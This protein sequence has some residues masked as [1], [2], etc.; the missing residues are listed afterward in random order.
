MYKHTL[1]VNGEY[2]AKA[3][4]LPS[5]AN[6]V[7]NGGSIKAGS[8]MGAVEVVMA[9]VDEVSIPASTLLTVQ[10]EGSDDN[11]NFALMPVNYALTTS[12]GVTTYKKGEEFARLPVPSNAP[13]HVRCRIATDKAGVTG[14]VDVFCDFLP[15]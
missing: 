6:A 15:R 3:Q 14:T 4:P 10:F 11:S 12:A 9:A 7:G 2:L 8:T 13:K 1:R 5:N